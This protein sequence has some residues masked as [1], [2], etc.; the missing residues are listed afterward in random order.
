MEIKNITPVLKNIGYAEKG[1]TRVF[2]DSFIMEM[3]KMRDLAKDKLEEAS[4]G[5]TG[6][7]YWTG[8]LQESIA[9]IITKNVP[10]A[11]EGVVGVDVS[12]N[13]DV[14][15]YAVPVELGHETGIG[16]T[17]RVP[18]YFY[19]ERAFLELSPGMLSRITK[20]LGRVVRTPWGLRNIAKGQWAPRSTPKHLIQ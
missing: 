17:D 18:G 1:L 14:E 3:D 12:R 9:S 2:K 8:R 13:P 16:E 20:M 4:M 5:Y 15:G 10:G 11:I 7:K 6:K 19:M